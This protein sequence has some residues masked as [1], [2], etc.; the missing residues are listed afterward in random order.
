MRAF[1]HHG[2]ANAPTK[3]LGKSSAQISL[4]A[5]DEDI[6]LEGVTEEP[7]VVASPWL[8]RSTPQHKDWA[9]ALPSSYDVT[10]CCLADDGYVAASS[11]SLEASSK[12]SYALVI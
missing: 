6:V 9:K 5:S 11:T 8:A 10:S 7:L 4:G 2:W 3:V 12:S 1:L